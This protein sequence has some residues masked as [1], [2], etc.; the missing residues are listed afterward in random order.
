MIMVVMLLMA[1]MIV[2]TLLYIYIEVVYKQRKQR[3][4]FS[5]RK[6]KVSDAGCY[7]WGGFR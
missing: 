6:Y 5:S 4:V 2:M 7:G 1:M 3:H